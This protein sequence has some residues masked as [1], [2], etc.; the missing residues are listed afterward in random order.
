MGRVYSQ[1]ISGLQEAMRIKKEK[2][3]GRSRVIR[4]G[5]VGGKRSSY[6]FKKS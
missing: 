2:S 3:K 6:K 1:E 4:S 5:I